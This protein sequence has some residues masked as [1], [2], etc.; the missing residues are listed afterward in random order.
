MNFCWYRNWIKIIAIELKESERQKNIVLFQNWILTTADCRTEPKYISKELCVYVATAK[1]AKRDRVLVECIVALRSSRVVCIWIHTPI[2][3]QYYILFFVC[4]S[5]QNFL[6][7]C[8]WLTEKISSWRSK[9]P[10]L[11]RKINSII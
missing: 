8:H 5:Q 7:Y 9:R 4:L 1:T 11:V 6:L 2:Y 10:V 3:R